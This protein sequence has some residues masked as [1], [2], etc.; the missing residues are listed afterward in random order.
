MSPMISQ[1]V[2]SLPP[3]SGESINELAVAPASALHEDSAIPANSIE[4]PILLRPFRVTD[5]A[6]MYDAAC[7]SMGQL[8]A[9]MTWCNSNY[10]FQDAENFVS[11]C[12]AA[13]DK[14]EH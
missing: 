12:P 6:P 3:V 9:W 11:Q 7:E 5:A 10:R 8:R 4:C 14:G 1:N 13:W 2:L